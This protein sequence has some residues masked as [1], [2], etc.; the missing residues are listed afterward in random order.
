MANDNEKITPMNRL[1]F[2]VK[3]NITG[4]TLV[5]PYNIIEIEKN[6]RVISSC[7]LQAKKVNIPAII[8]LN[9]NHQ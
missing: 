4:T 1:A 6:F 9:P 7:D 8:K 3:P 2:V 5:I